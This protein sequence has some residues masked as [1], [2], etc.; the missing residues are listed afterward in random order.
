MASGDDPVHAAA[1]KRVLRVDH[2]VVR[3]WAHT[4][5]WAPGSR[6]ADVVG[7]L[8]SDW[9]V[10]RSWDDLAESHAS[11]SGSSQTPTQAGHLFVLDVAEPPLWL[12]AGTRLYI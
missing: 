5:A 1:V 9:V 10:A 4:L 2:R 11:S 3:L 7:C 12:Y 6:A 8:G